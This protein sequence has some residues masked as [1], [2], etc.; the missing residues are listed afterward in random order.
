MHRLRYRALRAVAATTVTAVTVFGG[1]VGHGGEA[2]SLVCVASQVTDAIE[3]VGSE[4]RSLWLWRHLYAQENSAGQALAERGKRQTSVLELWDSARPSSSPVVRWRAGVIWP[5]LSSPELRSRT[6]ALAWD[7]TTSA[8][9]LLAV[10]CFDSFSG[11]GPSITAELSAHRVRLDEVPKGI[12][13]ARMGAAG[14]MS[15]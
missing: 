3:L 6:Y 11:I 1:S 14:T 10:T 15:A 5:I 4:E 8:A 12:L 7:G 2:P 13:P 9:W